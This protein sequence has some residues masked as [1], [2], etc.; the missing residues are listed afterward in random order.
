MPVPE[1]PDDPV[2][3]ALELLEHYRQRRDLTAM[4]LAEDLLRR[5]PE[6]DPARPV[7]LVVMAEL[8]VLRVRESDPLT[9]LDH[10]V[11]VARAA[12]DLAS[13]GDPIESLARSQLCWTLCQR[14]EA[15]GQLADLDEALRQGAAAVAG[16]TASPQDRAGGLR[17]LGNARRLR[18]ARFGQL[19]DLDEAVRLTRAAVATVDD[20]VGL[21]VSQGMLTTCLISRFMAL[22]RMGDADEAVE[23]GR[24]MLAGL[25]AEHI[26]RVMVQANLAHALWQ[27]HMRGGPAAD[28][29]EATRTSRE[30][31]T[32][33]PA[34]PRMRSQFL[35]NHAVVL[36]GHFLSGDSGG[37]VE[38]AVRAARE[39]VEGAA[40][41]DPK[42]SIHRSNLANM[43][44]VRARLGRDPVGVDEAVEIGRTAL[45]GLSPGDPDR[46]RALSVLATAFRVRHMI[47]GAPVDLDAAV[48]LW[49]SAVGSRVGPIEVRMGAATA[50]ANAATD[51][52]DAGLALEAY[53]VAV[54]L[55]PVL[56]WRGLDR[57]V[58]E[59][60]LA[61]S[62]GLGAEAA[63]WALAAGQPRRAVELLEHGRQVLW[64][65]AVQTRSDLSALAVAAPELA[66]RLDETRR[67]LDGEGADWSGGRAGGADPAG[68]EWLAV[69]ATGSG[70][71]GEA[72]HR[73]R[74][75]EHWE[76]LL[77]EARRQP[78]FEDFLAAPRFESLRRAADDGPVILVNT[79]RWR[80]DALVVTATEVYPVPLPWLD[81]DTAQN[82]AGALL[83]AQREAESGRG[84][85]A[86][87]HLRQTLISIQRWLW[88]TL[89]EPVCAALDEILGPAPAD[90]SGAG[91]GDG[92][93]AR[94]RV[95]WCPT[96]PLT[97][98]PL[99]AA[100]R[101][102]AGKELRDRRRP[103]VA[104]RVVSSYT[105]S[106]GAL[107]RARTGPAPARPPRVFAVG[108]AQTPG[109][110]PLPAVADELR[111]VGANLPGVRLLSG[112]GATT[113][114]V[115]AALGQHSWAHFAC[116]ARQDFDHPS[117]SA[118][119]LAD[120]QLS[121]LDLSS[122]STL[123]ARTGAGADLAYLSACRTAA[124]GRDLPDEAIHLTAALQLAG[125]RHVIG[126]QWAVSDRVA[127]QVAEA[128]YARL[129]AGGEPDASGAAYALDRAVARV[130][131]EQPDRP[132]LWASLIHTGP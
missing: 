18:Y 82:R 64:S 74:S 32:T 98:L 19:A 107:L 28:L 132:E 48:G 24:V 20:P 36:F 55:L 31:V 29:E 93:A 14:H 83:A 125:Y 45:A 127:A 111:A 77:A 124:G 94:R 120:G 8:I 42:L 46:C 79:T 100:G 85:L 72:D 40:S 2:D 34:Y 99:H 71:A 108:L 60:R 106:L 118:L 58:Q 57:S 101:Y 117:A 54:G 30:V 17:N 75:A 110:A 91:P 97:M 69:A 35:A 129:T 119:H 59:Q 113:S 44:L 116:H 62:A 65:Q 51:V 25:P 80:S 122:G 67:A 23:L 52:G 9:T 49:R 109:Q 78:G 95:W 39:A 43:V 88:D 21:L 3:R 41:D 87:T 131:E 56:A 50:W 86:R 12:V 89:A 68:F 105:S 7:A 53:S 63:A 102:G 70:T 130:R 81:H 61:K 15:T 96:G 16:A 128:V 84:P 66:A 11:D 90:G 47:T 13:P 5:V 115:L 10:A 4:S 92:S 1:E 26:E 6:S 112:S 33:L 37:H 103:T 104:A 73:R 38:A 123:A 126:S 27:R 22:G 121:V 114:A 76:R